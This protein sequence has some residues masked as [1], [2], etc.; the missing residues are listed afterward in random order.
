MEFL[1]FPCFL[2]LPRIV[3]HCRKSE[4]W[5]TF[6]GKVNS[7]E[8]A[9][10]LLFPI[11]FSSLFSATPSPAPWS[12]NRGSYGGATY[13]NTGLVVTANPANNSPLLSVTETTINF[14]YIVIG[15]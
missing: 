6:N 2:Q 15:K 5:G 14:K 9:K 4:Q 11:A 3:P 13:N 8:G 1:P 7:A 12:N 10:T